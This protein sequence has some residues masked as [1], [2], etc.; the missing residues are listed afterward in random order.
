MDFICT[1]CCGENERP[2]DLNDL[3]NPDSGLVLMK[4]TAINDKGQIVGES[5]NSKSEIH[6]FLLTPIEK[7]V[8][9]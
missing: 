5:R 2:I 8:A 7:T 9:K 6:A 4:A 3:I 1:P